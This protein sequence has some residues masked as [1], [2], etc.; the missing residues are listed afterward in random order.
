SPGA[1]V[2]ADHEPGG[3]SPRPP[4][5]PH[6]CTPR[7]EPLPFAR[8]SALARSE[9][10]APG[11][12]RASFLATRRRRIDHSSAL[13]LPL[14]HGLCYTASWHP[15]APRRDGRRNG[16]QEAVGAG[17]GRIGGGS[18]AKVEVFLSHSHEDNAFCTR[19]VQ[20]LHAAGAKVWYDERDLHPGRHIL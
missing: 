7:D 11:S 20:H 13:R 19:L 6:C 1:A 16:R 14:G 8:L 5:G 10:L 9:D 15:V 2:W 12:V 18:M 3:S 17:Q 4:G